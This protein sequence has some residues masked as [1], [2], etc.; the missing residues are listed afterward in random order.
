M[1]TLTTLVLFVSLLISGCKKAP[2]P[3]A[4]GSDDSYRLETPIPGGTQVGSVAFEITPVSTC[5]AGA[6]CFDASYSEQGRFARFRI[7]LE[8]GRS[9]VD[10]YKMVFGSG[11]LLPNEGSDSSLFVQK[12]MHA[13]EA[14]K[15][16]QKP[17]RVR[18]L[19]FEY[20]ILGEHQTREKDGGFVNKPGDWTAAKIFLGKGEDEGEVFLNF[21]AKAGKAEFSIKD[22]EYGDIVLAE[23]AKI[24]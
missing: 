22:P 7:I 6:H 20:V 24:L 1:R 13:L 19:P 3:A 16:P 8:A 17:Q 4:K 12:L 18:K 5:S 2:T 21:N 9:Q 10:K 11:Y 23:L 14:H 15:T